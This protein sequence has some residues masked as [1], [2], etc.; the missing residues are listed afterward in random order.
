MW[1]ELGWVATQAPP[2]IAQTVSSLWFSPF[3]ASIY[4]TFIYKFTI[5]SWCRLRLPVSMFFGNVLIWKSAPISNS[6]HNNRLNHLILRLTLK[7]HFWRFGEPPFSKSLSEIKMD[8]KPEVNELRAFRHR[9]YKLSVCVALS[10]S[11]NWS[12]ADCA[13]PASLKSLPRHDKKNFLFFISWWVPCIQLACCNIQ[14]SPSSP[15]LFIKYNITH[16]IIFLARKKK[17]FAVWWNFFVLIYTSFV[18]NWEQKNK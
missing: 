16:T 8:W 4:K 5:F 18:W 14:R 7:L 9:H 1:L 13:S 3:S 15:H 12:P 11:A 17:T 10:P 2:K 6:F